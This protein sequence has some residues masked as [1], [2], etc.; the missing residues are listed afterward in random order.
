MSDDILQEI[1][2]K[3]LEALLTA[4][5][6]VP[7]SDNVNLHNAALVRRLQAVL[8]LFNEN[9]ASIG[10]RVG[11][12]DHEIQNI[13]QGS[14]QL[15]ALQ[16]LVSG[17]RKIA[18]ELNERARRESA[19]WVP[20]RSTEAR[21]LIARVRKPLEDLCE[22]LRASN[23]IGSGYSVLTPAQRLQLIALLKALLAELEG[24]HVE[25]ARVGVVWNWMTTLLARGAEK[26][27]DDAV[28]TGMRGAVHALGELYVWLKN[29]RP[30]DLP[31]DDCDG[32]LEV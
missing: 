18:P 29:Q 21:R 6:A 32:G 3:Q 20:I 9:V 14:F 27:V 13:S 5:S 28:L 16:K 19:S 12:A 24:T 23:E 8:L 25:R 26:V 11:L 31:T 15:A 22:L 30:G 7:Q 17:I 10:E 1:T 4:L 2:F